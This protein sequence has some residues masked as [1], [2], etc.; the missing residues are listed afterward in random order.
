[1]LLSKNSYGL[2]IH[3]IGAIA[4]QMGK[5][6]AVSIKILL[7]MSN[8]NIVAHLDRSVLHQ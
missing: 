4:I 3:E 1:M 6:G 2:D 7:P 8:L 5:C